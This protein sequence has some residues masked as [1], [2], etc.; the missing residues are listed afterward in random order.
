MNNF[1]NPFFICIF[2]NIFDAKLKYV[3]NIII[4][5]LLFYLISIVK[6][7]VERFTL[8]IF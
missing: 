4:N 3:Q 7:N 1:Y 5:L 8:F 2:I 6:Y